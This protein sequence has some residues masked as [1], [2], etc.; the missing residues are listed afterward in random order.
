MWVRVY[1]CVCMMF[2]DITVLLEARLLLRWETM[3]RLVHWVVLERVCGLLL[4]RLL[5]RKLRF[6]LELSF[7]LGISNCDVLLIQATAVFIA[8]SERGSATNCSCNVRL[9]QAGG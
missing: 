6:V 9:T 5:C 3:A 4:L 1:L 7:I 2:W 8:S